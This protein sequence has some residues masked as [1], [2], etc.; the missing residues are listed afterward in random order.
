MI[1][2]KKLSTVVTVEWFEMLYSSI[3]MM[4]KYRSRKAMIRN[5]NPIAVVLTLTTVLVTED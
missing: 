1:E 3:L 5:P 2:M 4:G